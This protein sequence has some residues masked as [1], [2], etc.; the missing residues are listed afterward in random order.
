M[1]REIAINAP[2]DLEL[3]L[4]MGQAFRWQRLPD[5]FYPGGDQ[6]FSGVLSD[7]LIHI[8]QTDIGVEYR[9]GGPNGERSATLADDGVLRRYF[10]DDDD[11]EAIYADVGRRDKHIAQ[12]VRKY[13]GMRVLRQEPWE[14]LVAYVCSANNN[15]RQISNIAERIAAE[16]GDSVE[17]NGEVRCLFPPAERLAQDHA[18]GVL[19]RMSLGLRRAANIVSAARSVNSGALNLHA[20]RSSPYARATRE[21]RRCPGVGNKIADCI[22]L[23][24]LDK[25]QAFPVDV[26]IGRALAEWAD[27][28]FPSSAR[29]LTNRH[30]AAVGAWSRQ[31]FGPFA[32]YAGQ[33]IFCDQPKQAGARQS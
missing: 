33:F 9:L 12:L 5:G 1:V 19:E 17:L 14:C 32:G 30:Y 10:R 26:H 31:H 8:R 18:E 25:L 29:Q 23:F 27:Y 20:L 21:I 3:S 11:I 13:S 2:F 15:I 6:W 16:F 4:T 28:P 7:T 22:A 24:S